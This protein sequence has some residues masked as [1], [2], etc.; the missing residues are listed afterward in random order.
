[1]GNQRGHPKSFESGDDLI[2]LFDQFCQD[3]IENGYKCIPS[4]TEFCRFLQRRY[5][6]VDRRTIYNSLNKYFPD[7]KKRFEALQSDLIVQGA[8]LGAY[9]NTMSIFALKNW[10]DWSDKSET[11]AF[12]QNIDLSG[13]S[14]EDLKKLLY[15]E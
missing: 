4:Q 12:N 11:K 3:I 15:D 1:M 9:K 13:V 2:E 7:Y 6:S 10:C 8:M 5:K 14:T